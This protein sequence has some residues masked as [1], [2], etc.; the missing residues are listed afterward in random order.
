MRPADEAL[1][2]EYAASGHREVRRARRK[3]IDAAGNRQRLS[4]YLPS[5]KIE[6]QR[7]Q[8]S[9]TNVQ[10]VTLGRIHCRGNELRSRLGWEEILHYGK[11]GRPDDAQPPWAR[12]H[13]RLL[14]H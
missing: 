14:P 9:G 8:Y 3:L 12:R 5:A 6:R 2:R 13:I 1:I 7:Q 10:Q 11:I 4:R